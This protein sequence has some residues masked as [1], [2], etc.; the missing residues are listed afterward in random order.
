MKELTAKQ[1]Q[2]LK[3]IEQY[4]L[5]NGKSP[6]IREI[7][8]FL[9]VASDNSVLK[10]LAALQKKGYLTKD[11]TPRGI[12][13]LESVKSKLQSHILSIPV[14]GAI[15]AGG[16]VLAEEY[17]D[18]Y[19]SVD[20]NEVKN[21][22]QLYWLKVTGN[23]MIDAGIYE[24]DIVLCDPS[25]NPKVNDIVVA[26]VDGENTLKRLLKIEGRYFLKA[27]NSEYSDI[28][29]LNSLETQGVVIKLSRNYL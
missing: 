4:Q 3:F 20:A 10:H 28:H 1:S 23:S 2:V 22:S 12:G 9:Q 26:L 17:V 7:K 13:L 5:Q 27:E 24:G 14:L 11:D 18:S 15:P 8:E 29:P 19:L 6:T 25:R 16:P 21:A